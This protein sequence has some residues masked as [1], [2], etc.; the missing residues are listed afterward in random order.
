MSAYD[1]L[2]L[3]LMRGFLILGAI[4]AFFVV[5]MCLTALISALIDRFIHRP[6]KRAHRP[7][8]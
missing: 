1:A 6:A 5:V 7:Q 3:A 8:H 2:H 4:A